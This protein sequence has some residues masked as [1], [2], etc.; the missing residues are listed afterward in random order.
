MKTTC[1]LPDINECSQT[2][3]ICSNGRC[4]NMMGTYQCVCNDGYQQPGLKSHCEGE[5]SI[6]ITQMST[7]Q[8]AT[9]PCLFILVMAD[10]NECLENNGGCEEECINSR[11]SYSC[12]CRNGYELLP[13]GKSCSDVDECGVNPRICAGGECRNTDGSYICICNSG[14]IPSENGQRCE[15]KRPP[16]F[17]SHISSA[18]TVAF[19]LAQM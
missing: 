10:V 19:P 8:P 9:L 7:S 16:F 3:D 5:I 4:E 18:Y 6:F 11:G 17:L 14:Y 15:G 1:A 13:D 2:S 12:A